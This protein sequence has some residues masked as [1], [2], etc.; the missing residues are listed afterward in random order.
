LESDTLYL[1]YR[2]ANIDAKDG[3]VT[4]ATLRLP[5][6]SCNWGRFSL[7]ED[8]KVR[9]R[10]LPTDGCMSISVE[11]VR[12]QDYATTVHDP[13]CGSPIENYSH[14]EL[15]TV[16]EGSD[17]SV[18]PPQNGSKRAKKDRLAWRRHV[19]NRLKIEIEAVA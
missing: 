10:G 1:G 12:Y 19:R 13:I 4:T 9:E 2:L 14:C 18:E 7:P 6:L 16:Q 8:V 11:D 15:R 5:D 3:Q 17:T